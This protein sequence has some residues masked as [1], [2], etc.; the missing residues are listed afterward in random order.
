MSSENQMN[1]NAAWL[2]ALGAAVVAIV[3]TLAL[4]PVKPGAW[5]IIFGVIGAA[6]TVL[7]LASTKLT[8]ASVGGVVGR[9]AIASVL[10]GGF[11]FGYAHHL[12]G[13]AVDVAEGAGLS[14]TGATGGLAS[15]IG[16]MGGVFVVLL[17]VIG[18]L[19]GAVIGSRLRAGKGYGLIPA[20][21]S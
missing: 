19:S 1:K 18:S 15:I 8:A 10:V 7:A 4:N 17:M 9:F 16:T 21:K 12:M 5:K 11:Y 13:K 2:F 20:R 6:S 3:I 14:V